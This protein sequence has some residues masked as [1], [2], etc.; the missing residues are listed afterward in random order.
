MV[1]APLIAAIVAAAPAPSPTPTLAPIAHVV[2][3]DRALESIE[4]TARTTYVVT[5]SEIE[6]EGFL[7]IADALSDIPGVDVERYGSFGSLSNVSIR[8][9]SSG[10]VL[11][12]MNGMPVAGGQIASIDLAQI[13]T[14]GIERIEVVEGGGSTLYGSGSIGG[15]INIITAPPMR[16]TAQIMA[17]SFGEQ[18]LAIETP[19]VSLSRAIA[20]NDYSL[21]NGRTQQNADAS[22]SSVSTSL[23]HAVGA[24][25]AAFSGDL[26]DEHVGVP[27]PQGSYSP[28]S[29]EGTVDRNAVLNLSHET[30]HAT[31]SLQL[32]AST[33]D[34]SFRCDTLVDPQCPN[35]YLTPLAPYA[36]LLTDERTMADVRDVVRNAGEQ[37][38]YGIDLTRGDARVDDGVDPI[39][40]H[41]YDQVAAYV[42]SQW[43][44]RRGDELYAGLRGEN[45]GAP[46]GAGSP[47]IGGIERLT[48]ALSLRWNLA[49]AF[50]APTQEELYYPFFSNAHLISE[51]ARVGD[52]TLVDSGRAGSLQLGWF[53]T[54]GHDLIVDDPVTF[55]PENA[56]RAL[57]EGLTFGV[58]SRSFSGYS[59][60]LDVTNLY[61]AQDLDTNA[62]IAGRGPVFTVASGFDYLAPARSRIDGFGIETISKGPR[63]FVNPALPAFDQPVAY[64]RVDAYVGY[65][66]SPLLR[67]V[68]RGYNLAGARYSEF[69]TYSAAS[70]AF[71]AYPVPGRSFAVE[72]AAR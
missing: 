60:H 13:P 23:S 24:F 22:I 57:V 42:Q 59:A 3:S 1:I 62:R 12:L 2:T 47:S 33:S 69:G 65:R 53:A 50:R 5:K 30:A 44:D 43:F 51:H 11:V 17:G 20:A 10:Q 4:R 46:G 6:R 49:T 8:G 9:S 67:V 21:P 52:L 37:I 36:Q 34:L 54:A 14:A 40:F 16:T 70:A 68:L 55:L 71:Y 45:D 72:L 38:V 35:A 66:L 18:S 25:E 48:S 7:S 41:P 61:C 27:G 56:G 63:G 32:G 15:V 28:T 31:L 39:A 64:T 29:R 58:R 19:F 26:V